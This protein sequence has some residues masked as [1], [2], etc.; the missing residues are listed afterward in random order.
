MAIRGRTVQTPE[1]GARL[2]RQLAL[3]RSV[4][5]ACR[6]EKIGRATYYE[7]RKDDPAFAAAADAAIEE[8]TDRLEDV[9]RR[10]AEKESDTLLIFLLKARR[11]E[12]YRETMRHEMTGAGGGPIRVVFE[13]VTS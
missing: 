3:G 2:L 9:A 12:R 4:S 11:P 1:K 13:R 7:W 10:R 5:A 6:A 8:G